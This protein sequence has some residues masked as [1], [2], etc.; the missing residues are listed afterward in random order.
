M[1]INRD[2]MHINLYKEYIALVKIR[3]EQTGI[4][5]KDL[6]TVRVE[7]LVR[8]DK[9][10]RIRSKFDLRGIF[11]GIG[12]WDENVAEYYRTYGNKKNYPL[13]LKVN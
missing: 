8:L 12:Q 9:S 7:D 3:S 2:G 6:L 13:T 5:A 11:L 4:S 10:G 1:H